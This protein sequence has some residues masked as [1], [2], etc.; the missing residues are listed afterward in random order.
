MTKE[1]RNNKKSI[2]YIKPGYRL[3][4]GLIFTFVG[5]VLSSLIIYQQYFSTD[6][7]YARDNLHFIT[8]VLVQ[9]DYKEYA[10]PPAITQPEIICLY[11]LMHYTSFYTMNVLSK[12]DGFTDPDKNALSI[13]VLQANDT[14]IQTIYN[15]FQFSAA[16]VS[17]FLDKKLSK[18]MVKQVTDEWKQYDRAANQTLSTMFIQTSLVT[19]F[20]FGL[21]ATGISEIIIYLLKKKLLLIKTKAIKK[22]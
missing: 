20:S 9:E 16:C 19:I 10:A 1:N 6:A 4:T 3:V 17:M 12:K 11:K 21:L 15:S 7:K 14:D 13:M 8:S 22:K 18:D 5:M 2:L